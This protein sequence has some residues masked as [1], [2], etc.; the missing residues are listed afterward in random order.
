MKSLKNSQ[1]QRNI[2]IAAMKEELETKLRESLKKEILQDL[3][4]EIKGQYDEKIS[5]ME[6]T[7]SELRTQNQELTQQFEDIVSSQSNFEQIEN[8]WKN[9]IMESKQKEIKME[10]IFEIVRLQQQQYQAHSLNQE[11]K[12]SQKLASSKSASSEF[13][14]EEEEKEETL[15]LPKSYPKKKGKLI[16]VQ[17]EVK[18]E[19]TVVKHE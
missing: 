17:T 4:E 6:Q 9:T 12:L 7:I 3:K 14:Q 15:K 8:E 11:Q 5:K 13:L 19:P 1:E 2:E 18:S 16:M 10:D